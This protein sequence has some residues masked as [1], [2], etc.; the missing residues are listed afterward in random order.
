[1]LKIYKS[2]D[3]IKAINVIQGGI[4]GS[5]EGIISRL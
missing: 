4:Y 1:M 3:I 5:Q 2:C